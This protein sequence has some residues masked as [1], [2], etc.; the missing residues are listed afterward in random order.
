MAEDDTGRRQ[1]CLEEEIDE[2]EMTTFVNS[3]MVKMVLR[4]VH[5]S[6][7]CRSGYEAQV[8]RRLC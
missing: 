1:R 7:L 6:R 2:D 4:D 3:G 5:A 8:R